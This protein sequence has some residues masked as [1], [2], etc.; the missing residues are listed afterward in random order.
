MNKKYSIFHIEGGLGKH[1]AATA[2]ARCIKSNHEERE[3]IIVCSYP[4]VFLNLDFVSRVYRHGNTPYFYQTYIKGQDFLIF[5]HEPYFTTLHIKKESALIENWCDLYDLEYNGELPELNFNFRQHQFNQN[6]WYRD[7]PIFLLQTNGGPIDNQPYPYVWTRDIPHY[8]L[9]AIISEFK[10]QYHIIQV[11]RDE[12]QAINS[13]FVEVVYKP[14]SN[15]ELFGLVNQSSK[16]LLIDSSLQHAAVALNKPSTVLWIGTSPNVFGYDLHRNIISNLNDDGFN[17]P[18]SYLF[19]Y[20]FIGTLHECPVT[21]Q[22]TMFDIR[23][24]IDTL[25]TDKLI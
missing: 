12:R 15:M 25:K 4:E 6:L 11:C 10:D 2:V 17:L 1:I 5:K 8:L 7:K 22:T 20:N 3:L 21:D 9:D 24:I 13:E 19:D 14:M 18:D 16:R 23:E